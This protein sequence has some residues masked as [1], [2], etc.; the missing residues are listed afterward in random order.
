MRQNGRLATV[1]GVIPPLSES[2]PLKGDMP[3]KYVSATANDKKTSSHSFVGGYSFYFF[4]FRLFNDCE[5]GLCDLYELSHSL[6]KLFV[7]QQCYNQ[8]YKQ[9]L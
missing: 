8:S 7:L 4:A 6:L 3:Q 1:S 5:N 2:T 9:S